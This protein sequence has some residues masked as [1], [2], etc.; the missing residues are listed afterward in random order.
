[1]ACSVGLV[2]A[3]SLALTTP[4][5]IACAVAAFA[6]PVCAESDR[7][8]S[9]GAGATRG[10]V[11]VL[12][13]FFGA[14]GFARWGLFT[15]DHWISYKNRSVSVWCALSRWMALGAPDCSRTPGDVSWLRHFRPRTAPRARLGGVR[16]SL[17]PTTPGRVRAFAAVRLTDSSAGWRALRGLLLV[18]RDVLPARVLARVVCCLAARVLEPGPIGLGCS[19]WSLADAGGAARPR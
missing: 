16:V 17:G 3:L 15:G 6:W 4:E 1:M 9:A 2:C 5:P 14:D 11:K 18:P 8:P 19:A 10:L 7:P 12:L 13:R